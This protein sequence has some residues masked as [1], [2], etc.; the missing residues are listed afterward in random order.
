MI[1]EPSTQ[2]SFAGGV[3][4]DVV[5]PSEIGLDMARIRNVGK[6]SLR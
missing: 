5:R 4:L 6:I 2:V 3:L 1:G